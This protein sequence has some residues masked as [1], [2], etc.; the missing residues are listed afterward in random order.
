[1]N[2]QNYKWI[3]PSQI[4]SSSS[5]EEIA[6]WNKN[7][8]N[9]SNNIFSLTQDPKICNQLIHPSDSDWNINI[10]DSPEINILI[11]CC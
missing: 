6:V 7:H 8:Q 4:N 11:R 5:H 10:P 2:I 1:M 9:Y 3:I